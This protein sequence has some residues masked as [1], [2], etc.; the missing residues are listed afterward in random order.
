MKVPRAK[1]MSA[2]RS[3]RKRF[4]S[5]LR[6]QTTPIGRPPP[7]RLAVGDHVGADAEIFLRAAG[8]EPEA[9]EHLV[10]DQHDV[11]LGADLAQRLQ[12]FGV[13]GACRNARVRAL[14][15]SDGIA[16]APRR[17]DAAPAAD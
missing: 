16:R 14:S 17:S 1:Q 13:G 8:G 5:S 2:G 4:I 10:E 3:S 7:R 12:P 15:T 11:A 6:P 9:D